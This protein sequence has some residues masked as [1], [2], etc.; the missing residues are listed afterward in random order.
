[1]NGVSSKTST[2]GTSKQAIKN[3]TYRQQLL[4]NQVNQLELSSQLQ[5]ETRNWYKIKNTQVAKNKT[6]TSIYTDIDIHNKFKTVF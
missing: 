4:S 5:R 2:G 3:P 6:D 1:M